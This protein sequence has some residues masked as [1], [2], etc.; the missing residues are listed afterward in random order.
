VRH[1]RASSVPRAAGAPVGLQYSKAGHRS[2]KYT[3]GAAHFKHVVPCRFFPGEV[4]EDCDR[5]M[6]H[7]D[8]QLGMTLRGVGSGHLTLPPQKDG[9][10][11]PMAAAFTDRSARMREGCGMRE[12]MS[13]NEMVPASDASGSSL[14][15]QRC[16]ARPAGQL[17]CKVLGNELPVP[18]RGTDASLARSK[19]SKLAE[20]K[21][22]SEE[23][24]FRRAMGVKAKH[25]E[26]Q[27]ATQ[28]S[29]S[30]EQQH[31]ATS[32]TAL[33]GCC[34]PRR[35][36][37]ELESAPHHAR[38][39]CRADTR[40]R[41][42]VAMIV[43]PKESDPP[44]PRQITDCVKAEGACKEN[45][46]KP[47]HVRQQQQEQR[48]DARLALHRS[49]SLPPEPARNPIISEDCDTGRSS[50]WDCHSSSRPMLF[51]VSDVA[52][53]T[54]H[55]LL[56]SE[57]AAT[58]AERRACEKKFADLCTFAEAT[59]SKGPRNLAWLRNESSSM[60]SAL[61]WNA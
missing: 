61:A 31:S 13:F 44:P 39:R 43:T 53:L 22:E 7:L 30:S 34:S 37:I 56:M 59:T 9:Q 46:S 21:E 19:A 18:H 38:R 28:N 40:E 5:A 25:T 57:A 52:D 10:P 4:E 54:N 42:D 48:R 45:L 23:A 2:D 14:V 50:N 41:C 26:M 47:A 8:A 60:G 20:K 51:A 24:C 15:G 32:M 58:R 27:P 6:E 11:L 17:S 29:T 3:S 35:F 49:R 55:T 1:G 12:V 16:S 36:D 33:A